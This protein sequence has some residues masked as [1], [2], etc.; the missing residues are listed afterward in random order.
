MP[1]EVQDAY[2]SETPFS[3]NFL[4]VIYSVAALFVSDG[5]SI[6]TGDVVGCSLPIG[7][8]LPWD[9]FT[10]ELI[11]HRSLSLSISQVTY[12]FGLPYLLILW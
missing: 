11:C 3:Q 4:K 7:S 9:H 2:T 6:F 1:K 8:Q 5:Y 10:S 12:F